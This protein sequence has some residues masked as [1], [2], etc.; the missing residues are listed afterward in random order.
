MPRLAAFD[1]GTNTVQMV[2]AESDGTNPPIVILERVELTRLGEG[3]D[4]DRLLKP[5]A[6]DRTVKVLASFADEARHLGVTHFR[7]VAT[8]AARDASNSGELVRRT[9]DRARLALEVIDGDREAALVFR[10]VQ[11]EFGRAGEPLCAIDIGGG[12]TELVMGGGSGAPSSRTSLDIG[13]VRLTERCVS[14]HPI[15]Q[16]EQEAMRA[17]V[18]EALSQSSGERPAPAATVVAVAAT[19]TS[20]LAIARAR[21]QVSDTSNDTSGDTLT[22]ATLAT[23]VPEL[24]SM[25]LEQRRQVEG[26]DARRADVIC[27]G[28]WILLEVLGALGVRECRVTDRGVRWGL[29]RECAEQEGSR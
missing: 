6:M 29:L 25:S 17:Q 11:A 20:L 10:A 8:S 7:A 21:G 26:L 16:G 15:S 13:S 9:R 28:G 1:V 12:S 18:R 23:L 4:G 2:V 22:E 19:A 14:A 27:A 24:C 3:V 5:E